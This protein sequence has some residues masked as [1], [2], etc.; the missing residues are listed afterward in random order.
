MYQ[1]LQKIKRI[2]LKSLRVTMQQ[3]ALQRQTTF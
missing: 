1:C 2:L 3:H